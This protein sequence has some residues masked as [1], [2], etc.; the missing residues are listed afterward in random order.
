MASY[1]RVQGQNENAGNVAG[2]A[3][4]AGT[5]LGGANVTSRRY[6]YRFPYLNEDII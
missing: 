5:G 4:K 2:G 3:K 1:V 6:V